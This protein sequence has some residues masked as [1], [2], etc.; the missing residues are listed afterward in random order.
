MT[1]LLGQTRQQLALQW[2]QPIHRSGY[3]L[4]GSSVL[5]AVVGA[6][7]WLLATRLYSPASVGLNSTAISRR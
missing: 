4:A 1:A 3:L 7:F 6:G 5:S 2:R